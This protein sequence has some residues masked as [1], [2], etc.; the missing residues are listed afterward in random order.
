METNQVKLNKF[1]KMSKLSYR[2]FMKQD[3]MKNFT[4]S[5]SDLQR[6]N[7]YPIYPRGSETYSDKGVVNIDNGEQG[8]TH[9]TCLYITD[10]KSYQFKI[11]GC[12]S[13]KSLLKQLPKALIYHNYKIQDIS[14]K[15][16]GS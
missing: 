12:Q 10:N 5:Q 11:F 8:G 6:V 16:C 3:N 4:L 13:D 7:N 14:S 9:W 1:K 2:D 15:L